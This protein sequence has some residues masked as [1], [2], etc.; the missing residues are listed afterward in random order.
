MTTNGSTYNTPRKLIKFS[1]S[2]RLNFFLP[3]TLTRLGKCAVEQ[4]F[5]ISHSIFSVF[6]TSGKG[7]RL[8]AT[9]KVPE[10][11]NFYFPTRFPAMIS[12]LTV[13]VG[14]WCFGWSWKRWDLPVK[15]F[16]QKLSIFSEFRWKRDRSE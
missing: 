9:E 6:L 13:E 12:I 11:W 5:M 14:E 2:G 3:S 15:V 1:L 16:T 7:K 8:P 10:T 4:N